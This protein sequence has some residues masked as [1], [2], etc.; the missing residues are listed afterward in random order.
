MGVF[1]LWKPSGEIQVGRA[2]EA[3]EYPEGFSSS[4]IRRRRTLDRDRAPSATNNHRTAA[5]TVPEA[6][7]RHLLGSYFSLRTL[8]LGYIIVMRHPPCPGPTKWLL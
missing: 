3:I 6:A 7:N 4:T 2:G 5:I 8:L 1:S